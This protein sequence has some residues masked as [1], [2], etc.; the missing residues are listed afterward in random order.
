MPPLLVNFFIVSLKIFL[1]FSGLFC[2]IKLSLSLLLLKKSH[3]FFNA[4]TL[5][6]FTAHALL[7]LKA[8][9]FFVLKPLPFKFLCFAPHALFVLLPLILFILE[10]LPFQLFLLALS[11]ELLHLADLLILFLVAYSF[12]LEADA[13]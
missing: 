2:F 13:L 4:K 6:F 9:V 11:L 3:F 10:S 7:L 12:L 8:L 5:L 1:F